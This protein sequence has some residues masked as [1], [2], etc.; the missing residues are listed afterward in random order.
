MTSSL[1]SSL[2]KRIA[3]PKL[4]TRSYS[5]NDSLSFIEQMHREL[6]CQFCLGVLDD[7]RLLACLHSY[8]KQCI[9]CLEIKNMP[10]MYKCP[11]CQ[12]KFEIPNIDDLPPHKIANKKKRDMLLLQRISGEQMKCDL[13]PVPHKHAA[14]AI[15]LCFDCREDQQFICHDCSVNHYNKPELKDHQLELLQTLVET[16]TSPNGRSAARRTVMIRRSSV[17]SSICPKHG[18][19][20]RFFCET[21]K[22]SICDDCR[23]ASHSDHSI[24]TTTTVLEDIQQNI[25]TELLYVIGIRDGLQQSITPLRANKQQIIAQKDYLSGEISTRVAR[26]KKDL[27]L[28]ERILQNQLSRAAEAKVD[29]LSRQTR[30]INKLIDRADQIASMLSDVDKLSSQSDVLTTTRILLDRVD[31]LKKDYNDA[32]SMSKMALTT[33]PSKI[34]TL[35]HQLSLTPCEEAN[36][37]LILNADTIKAEIRDKSKIFTTTACPDLC[38]AMGPGLNTPEALKLTYFFIRLKDNAGIPCTSQQNVQALMTLKGKNKTTSESLKISHKGSGLYTVWFCP[39]DHGTCVIEIR[40]NE[41]HIN[42]SPFQLKV[43]PISPI[44]TKSQLFESKNVITFPVSITLDTMNDRVLVTNKGRRGESAIIV[45]SK[46]GEIINRIKDEQNMLKD[47]CGIASD[48]EGNIFVSSSFYHCVLKYNEAGEFIKRTGKIGRGVGDFQNPASI[49]WSNDNKELYVCD[50]SNCRIAV[51]DYDLQYERAISTDLTNT[52]G[53]LSQPSYPYDIALDSTGHM[54][55]TD[56]TNECIL[57]FKD[58]SFVT[59]FRHLDEDSGSLRTPKGIAI[60][61]DGCVYVSDS[62]I[63]N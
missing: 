35:Q 53:L 57:V 20:L 23:S 40:V 36:I 39:R 19:N 16:A 52:H 61:Q 45:M 48:N 38:T 24:N 31:M 22:T 41:V 47:P 29:F 30:E 54:F 44:S 59:A 55:I 49:H 32:V 43:L 7:P 18:L 2:A 11:E 1:T 13:C 10:S 26:I 37:G 50:T 60:D 6:T 62:G 51:F 58:G 9:M 42:N 28:E 8:C 63:I 15:Y 46:D 3:R 4:Q 5:T 27:D 34:A 17:F 21:C 14:P 33:G 25:P 56:I 12:E